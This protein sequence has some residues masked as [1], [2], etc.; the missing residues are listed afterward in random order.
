MPTNTQA[1]TLKV[2]QWM[3][4]NDLD[5]WNTLCKFFEIPEMGSDL[6]AEMISEDNDKYIH[7]CNF[8]DR[9]PTLTEMHYLIQPDLDLM[10]KIQCCTLNKLQ[11]MQM[12]WTTTKAEEERTK[13]EQALADKQAELDDNRVEFQR[14]SDDMAELMATIKKDLKKCKSANSSIAAKA[15]RKL[16]EKRDELKTAKAMIADLKKKL[17]NQMKRK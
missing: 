10:V 17:I 1:E 8:F 3:K 4:A 12:E 7:W 5:E 9:L 2:E 14:R 11:H 13:Y 6:E 16:D 15:N